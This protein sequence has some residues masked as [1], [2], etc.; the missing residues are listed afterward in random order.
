MSAFVGENVNTGL[1][2]LMGLGIATAFVPLNFV[3]ALGISVKPLLVK[4]SP[5]LSLFL[6]GLAIPWVEE[7]TF[8]TVFGASAVE[9]WGVVAGFA[10]IVPLWVIFHYLAW[11]PLTVG[12]IIYLALFR[13]FALIPL[14]KYKSVLPGFVGHV[15]VNTS[16]ALA[17][18]GVLA[19]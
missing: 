14:I 17:S 1:L 10:L 2:L 18:M 3:M 13:T 12:G 11:A 19:A 6:I 5:A 9:E 15:A 16:V 7:G 4:G 8:G